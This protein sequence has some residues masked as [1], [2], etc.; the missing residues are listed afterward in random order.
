MKYAVEISDLQFWDKTH[1]GKALQVFWLSQYLFLELTPEYFQLIIQQQKILL[2]ES[3]I[4]SLKVIRN[5]NI[6]VLQL[7]LILGWSWFW[8]CHI[9]LCTVFPANKKYSVGMNV[10]DSC[11]CNILWDEKTAVFH[12]ITEKS[13]QL[14]SF[15]L[16]LELLWRDVMKMKKTLSILSVLVV[17]FV[18]FCGWFFLFVLLFF[19]FF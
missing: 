9:R 1:Q 7:S 19:F 10:C 14:Q 3:I 4:W 5:E 18:C 6:F 11:V 16:P 2:G 8:K 12:V 15:S 13:H 17:V